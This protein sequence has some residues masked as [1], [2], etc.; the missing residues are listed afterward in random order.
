MNRIVLWNRYGMG[1]EKMH[2][3]FLLNAPKCTEFVRDRYGICAEY[4][5]NAYETRTEYVRFYGKHTEFV[6]PVRFPHEFHIST[7]RNSY[8]KRT[9]KRI[10]YVFRKNRTYSV[11]VSYAFRTYSTQI[12]Y[13]SRTNSVHFGA[14]NRK[15]PC[16][17]PYL[18]RKTIRF[19]YCFTVQI[20]YSF[21]T[22]SVPNFL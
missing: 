5:R 7:S 15:I 17:F 16:I 11:R 6:F 12:P 9:R 8:G 18:F 10:P 1:T 19:M 22:F 4:V 21:H 3:I 2:G 20:P 13:L 14:F